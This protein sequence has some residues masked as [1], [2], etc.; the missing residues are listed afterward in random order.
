MTFDIALRWELDGVILQRAGA[1]LEYGAGVRRRV[2]WS[3]AD[4][5]VAFAVFP[6]PSS[7]KSARALSEWMQ[8]AGFKAGA[9]GEASWEELDF[10]G[11][12]EPEIRALEDPVASFFA[13]HTMQQLYDGALERSILLA[14]AMT[15]REIVE[16]PQLEALDFWDEVAD[17]QHVARQVGGR[18]RYPRFLQSSEVRVGVRSRAPSP[19]EH[20]TEVYQNE[21]GI[22]AE[23]LRTLGDRGVI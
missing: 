21:L 3:C 5:W 18:L 8:E 20:N 14:P 6:A 15:V 10:F 2:H 4:G 16:S 13:A 9:F 12:S 1:A 19:G 23:R 22:S 11:M 7:H 17:P